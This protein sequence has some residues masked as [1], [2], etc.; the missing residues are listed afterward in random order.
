LITLRDV[1]ILLLMNR[2][3]RIFGELRGGGGRAVMPF[4]T[5][6]D[7]DL[8]TTALLLEAIQRAGAAV[9]ELGIPFSD[10]IADGPVIQASM[11]RALGRGVRPEQVL[12][13]VSTV[14]PKLTMG[15]VAMVS[16]SIVHRMGPRSFFAQAAEAGFDGLILPDLPLE[17]SPST[18]AEVREAGLTCSM[19]V[20]PTSP[21]ERAAAIAEASTGFVY[22]LARAGITGERNGVPADLPDRISRLRQA[23]DLP[24]AVGFGIGTPQQVA[25]V[26]RVADAAIVGSAI[27]RRIQEADGVDRSATA[28]DVESFVGDLV[29][30][31]SP[32][33]SG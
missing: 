11:S 22:V 29:A 12:E 3:D 23:S 27:V 13:M 14:R 15:L 8:E 26:C 19:L 7:P 16:F 10:P 6:G 21:D 30:G 17:E 28:A 18:L 2:I 4:I 33:G 5:A 9:C 20:A 31:L 1:S 32:G 25:D 24:M